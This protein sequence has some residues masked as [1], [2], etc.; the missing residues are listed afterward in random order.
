MLKKRTDLNKE[1]TTQDNNLEAKSTGTENTENITEEEKKNLHDVL[2]TP[3]DSE[4]TNLPVVIQDNS[5]ESVMPALAKP[6]VFPKFY[7]IEDAQAEGTDLPTTTK[8]QL[9]SLKAIMPEMDFAQLSILQLDAISEY[10]KKIATM[11]NMEIAKIMEKYMWN[12]FYDDLDDAS[13]NR[14]NNIQTRMK[15]EDYI[16]GP[17]METLEDMA[18]RIIQN[19]N[20]RHNIN[21]LEDANGKTYDK[22]YRSPIKTLLTFIEI[23]KNVYPERTKEIVRTL[24]QP[25][26]EFMHQ[27]VNLVLQLVFDK[28]WNENRRGKKEFFWE[29]QNENLKTKLK[30]I[31]SIM[32]RAEITQEITPRQQNLVL[33][34]LNKYREALK[35]IGM[36]RWEDEEKRIKNLIDN[37]EW[38]IK[39]NEAMAYWEI[40]EMFDDRITGK[41]SQRIRENESFPSVAEMVNSI[42]VPKWPK[43]YAFRNVMKSWILNEPL[44][45]FI[46][47][48]F[49]SDEDE[50]IAIKAEKVQDFKNQY[51]FLSSSLVVERFFKTL[52][53]YL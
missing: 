36:T 52:D 41:M 29:E 20:K 5:Y 27:H 19:M 49:G 24:I 12:M 18:Q 14:L 53:Q 1:K 42:Y 22:T 33:D 47:E 30:Q 26:H 8:E 39:E 25:F 43:S 35:L 7:T 9:E 15:E 28:E 37:D 3:V 31:R 45:E 11:G 38:R 34:I 23:Q 40:L 4:A 13:Y 21:I 6:I 17:K 51:S 10:N 32:Y 2:E 46:E 44:K 48:Y 50:R 16:R